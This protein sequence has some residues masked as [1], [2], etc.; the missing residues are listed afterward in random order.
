MVCFSSKKF[1]KATYA[2]FRSS[3]ALDRFADASDD[4]TRRS[5][6]KWA[7]AW[8]CLV[9]KDVTSIVFAKADNDHQLPEIPKSDLST[10]ANSATA[11]IVSSGATRVYS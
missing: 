1:S 5:A 3:L 10:A 8:L 2:R 11:Q 6:I 7:N 4:L 9:T